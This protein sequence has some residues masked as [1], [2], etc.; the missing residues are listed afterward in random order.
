MNSGQQK[1]TLST[2]LMQRWLR[3]YAVWLTVLPVLASSLAQAAQTLDISLTMG[4]NYTEWHP[5]IISTTNGY[6]VNDVTY[7]PFGTSIRCYDMTVD[8]DP[9]IS[10]SVDVVN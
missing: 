8:F 5:A 10:A 7:N 6:R 9:F 2:S 1:R 4:S 3:K